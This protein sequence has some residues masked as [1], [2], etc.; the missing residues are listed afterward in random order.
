MATVQRELVE[1]VDILLGKG[2]SVEL[3][4]E[5]GRTALHIAA[6][7]GRA[8]VIG[9]LLRRGA[10]VDAA[11]LSKWTPLMLAAYRGHKETVKLLVKEGASLTVK[12]KD[13]AKAAEI[14]KLNNRTDLLDL[15]QSGIDL[16]R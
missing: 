8:D 6:E 14:A 16:E 5:D 15:L 13:G 7:E 10:N 9:L 11:N 12:N 1:V 4:T 3:K 2:A